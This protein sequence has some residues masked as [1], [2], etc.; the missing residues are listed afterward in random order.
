MKTTVSAAELAT[1]LDH[2]SYDQKGRLIITSSV[3]IEVTAKSLTVSANDTQIATANTIKAKRSDDFSCCVDARRLAAALIGLKEDVTLICEDTE[4][5]LKTKHTKYSLALL[6][7]SQFPSVRDD[8]ATKVPTNIKPENFKRALNLGYLVSQASTPY[9]LR[10]LCIQGNAAAAIH[11]PTA[12]VGCV[13]MDNG[14]FPEVL[15]PPPALNR[16]AGFVTDETIFSV[17]AVPNGDTWRAARFMAEKPGGEIVVQLVEGQYPNWQMLATDTDDALWSIEVSYQDL[18]TVLRR[19]TKFNTG[20]AP[21]FVITPAEGG[22]SFKLNQQKADEFI[23]AKVEGDLKTVALN[24]E[25][26][27]QTAA[28]F[29]KEAPI[30]LYGGCGHKKHLVAVASDKQPDETHYT[31]VYE[32]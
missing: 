4:L 31:A 15:L 2:S 10:S 32:V 23:E 25:F 28:R 22:L 26:L 21:S 11:S 9:Q 19:L 29:P 7:V 24:A 12:R 20:V 5:T 14:E 18:D 16:L 27:L 8:G 30:K 1:A 17:M 3:L 6:P 13:W